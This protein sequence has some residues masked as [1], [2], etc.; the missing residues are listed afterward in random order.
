MC[1]K[2]LAFRKN[3]HFSY[4]AMPVERPFFFVCFDNVRVR[5]FSIAQRP[6]KASTATFFINK[7]RGEH[8]HSIHLCIYVSITDIQPVK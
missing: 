4:L 2:T 1:A 8:Q 6:V 3:G 5:H 7:A